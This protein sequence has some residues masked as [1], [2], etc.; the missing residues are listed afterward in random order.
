MADEREALTHEFL[1]KRERINEGAHQHRTLRDRL[2]DETRRHARQRDELNAQ[3]RGIVETANQHRAKRDE[4]NARV[5]EGKQQRDALNRLVQEKI[6]A[7][8]ALRKDQGAGGAEGAVPLAKLKSELRRLE[9]EQ[10]TKVF[11]PQ[12]EKA[13][14]EQIALRLKEIREREGS[15]AEG[16]DARKAYEEM[17]AAKAQAE[18]QHRQVTAL[19]QEAQAEHER[20]VALFSQ[21]DTLRKQADAEQAEF[22]RN[23]V[24]ADRVHHEYIESI[25]Q[26]RD[27]EKVVHAMRAAAGLRGPEPGDRTPAPA[28]SDRAA[29]DE[30]FDRFR[31]GEKLSTEDLMA[32]QKGGRL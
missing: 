27:L 6:E 5:R 24:E 26:I 18:E 31:K 9:Y 1:E 13:L 23:K 12:K 20:M 2:N 14:I 3:V 15:H 30:I 19:A 8:Q 29:A 28:A 4:L 7:L 11:S 21:A 25:Q 22:V 17:R 32:L 16:D 10:Q